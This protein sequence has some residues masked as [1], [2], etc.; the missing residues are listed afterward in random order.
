MNIP[1]EKSPAREL[2]IWNEEA[3]ELFFGEGLGIDDVWKWTVTLGGESDRARLFD[4]L[5]ID[6]S[7]P[8]HQDFIRNKEG[9]PGL[10]F[11]YSTPIEGV[12]L[13]LTLKAVLNIRESLSILRSLN[14]YPVIY[15]LGKEINQCYLQSIGNC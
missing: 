10:N 11:L 13:E 1:T 5:E 8:F 9:V 15:R 12:Y 3:I 14:G 6:L 7:A 4:S 2:A